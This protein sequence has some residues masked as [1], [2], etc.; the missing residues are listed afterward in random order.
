MFTNELKGDKVILTA[1]EVWDG[2]AQQPQARYL[3]DKLQEKWP[4][5]LV[6]TSNKFIIL[7]PNPEQRAQLAELV[8]KHALVE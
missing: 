1:Y 4:V 8:A 3:L 7:W 2:A 5:C 6:F